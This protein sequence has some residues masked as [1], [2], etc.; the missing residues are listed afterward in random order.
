MAGKTYLVWKDPAAAKREDNWI[1]M[2]GREFHLFL[3]RPESKQRYFIRMTDETGESS[4]IYIEATKDQ[5]DEWRRDQGRQRY[6][7]KQTEGIRVL[8]ADR[9]VTREETLLDMIPEEDADPEELYL[10]K[11]RC[12]CVKAMMRSLTDLERDL[13]RMYCDDQAVSTR[14]LAEK[15][16]KSVSTLKRRRKKLKRRL[17][18][19]LK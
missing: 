15:Y 2:S 18:D 7:R 10:R 14:E 12:E 4:T 5:Y 13:L 17:R 9:P 6:L 3:K 1:R 19:T 11:E 16:G 8:S